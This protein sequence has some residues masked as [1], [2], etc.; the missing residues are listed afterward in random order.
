[1]LMCSW[2]LCHNLFNRSNVLALLYLLLL[3]DSGSHLADLLG[4]L[5]VSGLQLTE[6]LLQ[7][8]DGVR[9]EVERDAQVTDLSTQ[10][11]LL[12]LQVRDLHLTLLKHTNIIIHT[13]CKH[14]Y[15]KHQAHMQEQKHIQDKHHT[16]KIIQTHKNT[17]NIN[18]NN[19]H[20]HACLY[21]HTNTNNYTNKHIINTNSKANIHI[22]THIT[23]I[24]KLKSKYTEI[25]H[26]TQ[27]KQII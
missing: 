13:S 11:L 24:N 4:A 3:F 17:N 5:L 1:M 2:L 26:N 12:L 16:H 7:F 10:F 19:T 22:K 6:L 25:A 23:K 9:G 15:R 27:C 20:K 18:T 8:R 21:T 14:K